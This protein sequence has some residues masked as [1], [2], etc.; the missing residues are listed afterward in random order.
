MT[1]IQEIPT[2]NSN[3]NSNSNSAILSSSTGRNHSP[4]RNRNPARIDW[5][6]DAST[7]LRTPVGRGVRVKTRTAWSCA[8]WWSRGAGDAWR[9]PPVLRFDPRVGR[10]APGQLSSAKHKRPIRNE[11]TSL[12]SAE[13]TTSGCPSKT[14]SGHTSFSFRA[15]S[16]VNIGEL[17]PRLRLG[18][19]RAGSKAG[20]DVDRRPSASTR[21]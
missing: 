9:Q 19:D 12:A 7:H 13:K 5:R 2:A 6:I 10:A 14:C 21:G 4:R 18:R 11:K 20:A 15:T 17:P 3:S 1:V 16:L 8:P